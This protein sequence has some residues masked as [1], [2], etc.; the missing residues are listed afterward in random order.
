MALQANV[1]LL[2][3]LAFLN[4]VTGTALLK[5]GSI[6]YQCVYTF[7]SDMED[8][9]VN[10]FIFLGFYLDNRTTATTIREKCQC[11]EETDTVRWRKVTD[12]TIIP[13]DPLCNKIQIM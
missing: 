2:L 1:G 3:F 6:Y 13:K 12:F 5:H 8:T 9:W 4:I 10:G 7:Q 11:V